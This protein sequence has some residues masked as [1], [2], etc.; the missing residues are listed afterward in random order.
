MKNTDKIFYNSTIL[1]VDDIPDNLQVLGNIFAPKNANLIVAT[2]G[3]TAIN[4]AKED[5][6]DIILLDI[7]MPGTNG[8]DVAKALKEDVNTK[9]IPI[10]FITAK[11]STEDV[12]KGFQLGAV[13]YITKPFNS[14]ELLM[15]VSTHLELAKTRKELVN[16]V[17]DKNKFIS[18]V[19]HDIKSPLGG[20]MQLMKILAEDFSNIESGEQ[21]EIVN[22]VYE[23]IVNQYKFVEDLLNWG[24][25]QLDR[26]EI[27]KEPIS[28]HR[29]IESVINIQKLNAAN[30]NIS[31]IERINSKQ[32][33]FADPTHTEN[34]I[35]NLLSNA[36]KFSKEN[37]EIII[38]AN[39]DL[40]N[41]IISITDSG[42]GINES[43]KQ[44]LFKKSIIHTTRGTND[45]SGTG[46]GLLL[47]KEMLEKNNGTIHF[48]SELGKGT[49]FFITLPTG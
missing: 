38:E 29:I 5:I 6:P 14:A 43:D 35:S 18:L 44:R 41:I 46:L 15:R 25:L 37:S 36:I 2:D 27:N 16:M 13:D 49:T 1:I 8:Y 20:V 48:E 26:I 7:A 47:V 9:D 24:R 34:I 45:E 21:Q 33:I 19:A 17:D 32:N 3:E 39:D 28:P 40:D 23:S 10:I 42:V 12:Q 22:D 4:N 11:T 30:K 31:L